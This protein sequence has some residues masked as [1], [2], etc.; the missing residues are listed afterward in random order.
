M[1]LPFWNI[2]S[3]GQAF[4]FYLNTLTFLL[5]TF[6]FS[7]CP[8]KKKYQDLHPFFIFAEERSYYHI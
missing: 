7:L 5:S 1:Y 6:Y 3:S 8:F 2:A 4:I